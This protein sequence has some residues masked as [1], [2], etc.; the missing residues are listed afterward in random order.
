MTDTWIPVTDK[1]PNFHLKKY[2]VM[3]KKGTPQSERGIIAI[4][5]MTTKTLLTGEK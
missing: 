2:E 5:V 3:K 1:L 4:G